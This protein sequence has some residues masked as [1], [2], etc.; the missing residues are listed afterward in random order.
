MDN[1]LLVKPLACHLKGLLGK[2]DRSPDARIT[3]SVIDCAVFLLIEL[4]RLDGEV[5]YE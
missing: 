4:S 2:I 3:Q 1:S 5:T